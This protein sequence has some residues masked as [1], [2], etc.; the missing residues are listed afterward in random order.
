M[1]QVSSFFASLNWAAPTWDVFILLFFIVGALLYG[2]SLGRD[3]IIVILVSMYM[4][5]AVAAN[6]PVLAKINWQFAVNGNSIVRVAFFL[7][8]F[9]A[10][11]FLMARSALLK[12][13]GGS[14]A[15]GSWWQTI[16]FSILQVGLLISITLSFLPDDVTRGLSQ[17]TRDIF[18]SDNGKSAWM[19]LPIVF[20][21]IAPRH[22]QP[23]QHF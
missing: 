9:V 18:M 16:V 22:K 6:T 17:M 2:L 19:L 20:M 1:G 5:L 11:F 13:L 3:R 14:G 21:I 7:G 8:V 15:P 12:T 23:S 4:A 10:V